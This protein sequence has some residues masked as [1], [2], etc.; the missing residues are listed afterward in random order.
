MLTRREVPLQ[1]PD[2]ISGPS[3]MSTTHHGTPN[4]MDRSHHLTPKGKGE[5]MHQSAVAQRRL[6]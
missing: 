3:S 1:T 6:D 4:R 2:L 5:G